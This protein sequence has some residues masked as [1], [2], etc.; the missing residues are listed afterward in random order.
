MQHLSEGG[1]FKAVIVG[2]VAVFQQ[3]IFLVN[4]FTNDF[5]MIQFWNLIYIM[6]NTIFFETVFSEIQL[7]HEK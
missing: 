6:L 1:F 2:V 7:D 5:T 4:D 3:Q